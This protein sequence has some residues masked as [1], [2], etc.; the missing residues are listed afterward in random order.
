VIVGLIL[1]GII[2]PTLFTNP[3]DA[4][5][6]C[7][8]NLL[9]LA[10]AP[11]VLDA[12]DLIS[13]VGGVM[14]AAGF[15]AVVAGKWRSATPAA[16]LAL[17]PVVAAGVLLG[18]VTFGDQVAQLIGVEPARSPAWRTV[19]LVT[20]LASALGFLAG[21]LR[22]RLTRS[23]IGKLVIELGRST[24][25]TGG[26]REALAKQLGDPSLEIAYRIP[27]RGG[28]VDAAGQTMELPPEG[29][30]RAFTLLESDGQPVAALIH[31]EFLSHEPEIVEAVA[32]AARLAIVNEGLRA[33]V[34]AK[35]E[36]VR[37]SRA[38]I[39]QAGDAER[40][41]VERNL[42]DGA[43]QRLVTLSLSLGL[44]RNRIDEKEEPDL[45]GQIDAL[46]KEL[47]ET[48]A[49]V[50]EL[51]RGI[52]P[53]ILTEEGLLAAVQSLAER[54]PVP[55]ILD[56]SPIDRLP[57]PVEATAYFVVAEAL[58]NVA[59]YARA[60]RVTVRLTRG[61]PALEVEVADDGQGG[62]DPQTGSGLRG[63]H[64]RVAAMGGELFLESPP[65]A[66]TRVRAEIPCDG[67]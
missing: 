55:I 49:E 41:R 62:A 17:A 61:D 3:L 36:E 28:Y 23:A 48:M 10:D 53:A 16:R 18:I 63:L 2:L 67:R 35:L 66:G 52:H 6:S 50:R 37:A 42:H 46:S 43:Q 39:V 8:R 25:L 31:D 15:V 40:R 21:L 7:P 29:S 58:T 33:E 1:P 47:R 12:L 9:L 45:A 59:K 65:G 54:S 24:R 26:L 14:A 5:P 4:C 56:L 64:D 38:R 44:V 13:T 60:S 11:T 19:R 32:A 27:E 22:T 20:I 57:G 30:G 34:Q 51:A